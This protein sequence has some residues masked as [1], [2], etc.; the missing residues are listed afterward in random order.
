MHFIYWKYEGH[1]GD[2]FYF[3][4]GYLA[5]EYAPSSTSVSVRRFS[6]L[7]QKG[8]APGYLNNSE[9]Y[10]VFRKS[11]FKSKGDRAVALELMGKSGSVTVFNDDVAFYDDLKDIGVTESVMHKRNPY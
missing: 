7:N 4:D 1:G 11:V 10:Q 3:S 5:S 9:V 8:H 2:K 6:W